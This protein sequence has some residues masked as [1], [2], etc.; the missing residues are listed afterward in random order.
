MPVSESTSETAVV[1]IA[2]ADDVP[3]L[4][5]EPAFERVIL[6]FPDTES[7]RALEAIAQ[8][9][10]SLVVLDRGFVG[11]SRGAAIINRI[12]TDPALSH[13]KIRVLG[14]TSEYVKLVSRRV[15]KGLSVISAIPGEALPDDYR[16]T[17][18]AAR[19][20]LAAGL[21]IR[22][23]GERAHLVDLSHTGAQI[24]VPSSLRPG[25]RVRV[26]L[27]DDERTL[28]LL[29][30]VVWAAF[31]PARGGRPAGYRV[32]VVFMDTETK[33]IEAFCSRHR[34]R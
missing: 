6:V 26:S 32:G 1:L 34:K 22:L 31:E 19:I 13:S 14:Q 18:V 17:R 7:L 8:H 27:A 23:D 16:G 20:E 9:R 24:Q 15:E 33:P 12:R 30:L 21:D 25:Q 3:S 29:G 4:K 5:S 10:P 2:P 11:S 28:R